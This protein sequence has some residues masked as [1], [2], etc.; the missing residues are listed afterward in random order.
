MGVGVLDDEEIK[1]GQG[2]D[3][4]DAPLRS[5][6]EILAQALLDQGYLDLQEAFIDGHDL[7]PLAAFRFADASASLLGSRTFGGSSCAMND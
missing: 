6:L 1:I 7:R 3:K 4:P 5:I 2:V